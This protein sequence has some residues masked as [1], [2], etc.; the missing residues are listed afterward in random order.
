MTT[1]HH[2]RLIDGMRARD[3][4]SERTPAGSGVSGPGYHRAFL[5]TDEH[6]GSGGTERLEHRAQCVAEHDALLTLLTLRWGEPELVS[7]WSAQARMAAGE[8]IAEPW[9]DPV[10]SCEYLQ[11]W[12]IEERWIALGLHQQDSGPGCELSVLVTVVDPP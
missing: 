8:E 10:A 2:L 7:L 3:F 1:A 11:L 6:W 12:R 5:H 9:A 4:P